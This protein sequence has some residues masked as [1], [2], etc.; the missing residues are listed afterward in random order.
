MEP[1]HCNKHFCYWSMISQYNLEKSFDLFELQ[2]TNSNCICFEELNEVAKFVSFLCFS[3]SPARKTLI[4]APKSVQIYLSIEKR[5]ILVERRLGSE[6]CRKP[7]CKPFGDKMQK[8]GTV[9]GLCE[10]SIC[11]FYKLPYE[12]ATTIGPSSFRNE[13]ILRDRLLI[14]LRFA[15]P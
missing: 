1:K 11:F 2:K 12:M 3:P 9:G 13:Q 7:T 15:A 8:A 5:K 10:L 14:S 4:F 6:I